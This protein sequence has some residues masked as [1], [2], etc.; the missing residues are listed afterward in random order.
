MNAGKAGKGF[1]MTTRRTFVGALASAALLRK[2]VFGDGRVPLSVRLVTGGDFFRFTPP[3]GCNLVLVDL[4][5]AMRYPSHP[6]IATANSRPADEV[7]ACVRKLR[8]QGVRTVPLL[9]FSTVGDGWLGV[10]D[11]MVCSSVY[12]K[13]LP[14]LIGD[15]FRAFESPEYIHIGFAR[16]DWKATCGKGQPYVLMRIGNLWWRWFKYTADC[17]R[18]T[19]ARPWAWFDYQW[20]LSDVPAEAPK[21]VVFSNFRRLADQQESESADKKTI[22]DGLRLLSENGFTLVPWLRDGETFDGRGVIGSLN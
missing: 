21:D 13:L 4:Q 2:S 19:G 5:D 9:D 12:K 20:R 7:T 11:R 22:G 18:K 3:E 17:V 6:E 15:A 10:Y 16:E 8:A 14:E 1:E